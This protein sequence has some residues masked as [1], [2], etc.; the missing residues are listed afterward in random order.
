[1]PL[2]RNC[3]A[4]VA[5][6]LT[7]GCALPPNTALR[8][9]ARTASVLADHP[10]A[11]APP[12]EAAP[13]P[14]SRRAPRQ[15]PAPEDEAAPA[16]RDGLAAQQE[17]LAIYLYALGVLAEEEQ[18][19][20]FREDAYAALAMRAAAADAAAARAVGEIGAI[21]RAA[22][23]ANLPPGARANS[24][25]QATVV[26]DLRLRGV[27]HAADAPV[28]TLVAALSAGI[29]ATGGGEARQVED[30]EAYLRVLA[31][32][33]EG[34]AMLKA[35]ARH[36]TQEEVARELRAQEDRLR[37]AAI[38]LPADP[39]IAARR[40]VGGVVAAVVQP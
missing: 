35:R 23:D 19:L 40:P 10:A 24:A 20:T 26:E 32:I 33:G 2:P 31:A 17:A 11:I 3:F 34:H 39:V 27:I 15:P 12:P 8:D 38:R 22:R 16:R 4:L 1:M 18:P 21:L 30:R 9:W 29:A 36:I 28:Q 14:A 25:G 13:P 6:V 7:A 5:L 37:R